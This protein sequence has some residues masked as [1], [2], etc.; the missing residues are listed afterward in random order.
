MEERFIYQIVAD[1][2]SATPIEKAIVKMYCLEEAK[3]LHPL[4]ADA[5]IKQA[6]EL[7]FW[8]TQ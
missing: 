1:Y 4:S 8:L 2:A 7:L 6:D 3:G 5:L